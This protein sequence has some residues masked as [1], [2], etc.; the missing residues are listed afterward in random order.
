MYIRSALSY[1]YEAILAGEYIS[2]SL[3][4]LQRT[5]ETVMQRQGLRAIGTSDIL[6]T[7]KMIISVVENTSSSNPSPLECG[8]LDDLVMHRASGETA[9]VGDRSTGLTELCEGRTMFTA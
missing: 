1:E 6:Q 5:H 2:S 8:L 7:G 3:T 9:W 4:Y